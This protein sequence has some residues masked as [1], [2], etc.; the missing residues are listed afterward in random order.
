[1][2]YN[3]SKHKAITVYVHGVEVTCHNVIFYPY[4]PATEID[5]PEQ[6]MC[7]WDKVTIGG[8]E[9]QELFSGGKLSDD[10]EAAIIGQLEAA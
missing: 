7:E 2:S 6:P 5:P 10:L 3:T 8:V 9:V 4:V 1:M